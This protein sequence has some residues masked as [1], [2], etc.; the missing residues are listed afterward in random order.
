VP[1]ILGQGVGAMLAPFHDEFVEGGIYGEW[2]IASEAREA[3]CVYLGTRRTPH[4]FNVQIADA[5]RVE[6]CESTSHGES[7]TT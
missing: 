4:P 7:N 3:K 6:V 5:L 1:L 2:I